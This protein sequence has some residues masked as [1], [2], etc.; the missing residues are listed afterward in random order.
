[1]L[2]L[3]ITH[4]SL[5]RSDGKAVQFQT[6]VYTAVLSQTV[7]IIKRLGSFLNKSDLPPT[8]DSEALKVQS[9]VAAVHHHPNADLLE[10]PNGTV[11]SFG[12]PFKLI[13]SSAS[14]RG[15]NEQP[16]HS[17]L[18]RTLPTAVTTYNK[19]Q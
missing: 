10:Q 5:L 15:E 11:P 16:G 8:Q 3:S 13:F 12:K 4:K 19:S 2:F 18:M 17:C 14:S 6:L 1:M 9:L 7:A